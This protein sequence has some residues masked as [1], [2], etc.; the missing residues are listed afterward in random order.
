V[1]R[2]TNEYIEKNDPYNAFKKEMLVNVY[3]DE[4]KTVLDV[5]RKIVH[6]QLYDSYKIWFKDNYPTAKMPTSG[7]VKREMVRRLGEP[8]GSAWVGIALVDNSAV[9]IVKK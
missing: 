5:N 4:T 8:V 6:K 7:V 1:A 9:P 2:Y 3:T